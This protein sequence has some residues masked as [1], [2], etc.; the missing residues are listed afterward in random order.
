MGGLVGASGERKAEDEGEKQ[1]E[2]MQTETDGHD[3]SIL[4]CLKE[5]AEC[6][7]AAGDV[8]GVAGEAE[9]GVGVHHHHWG[10]LQVPPLLC[11]MKEN[12]NNLVG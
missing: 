3:A 12:G 6:G 2:T 10:K 1:S 9:A 7:A 4:L 5:A 8:A 11:G